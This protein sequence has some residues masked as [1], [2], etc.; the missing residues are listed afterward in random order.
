MGALFGAVLTGAALMGAGALVLSGVAGVLTVITNVATGQPW[1]KNLLANMLLIGL[2][3]KFFKGRLFVEERPSSNLDQPGPV[4]DQPGPVPKP[5]HPG[6]GNIPKAAELSG[7]GQAPD[8]GAFTRAG[9]AFQK[10]GS[11]NPNTWGKPK[12]SPADMNSTGQGILD[13]IINSPDTS[14]QTRHHA[15]F[16][17]VVEGRLPDGRGAR[18]SGDGRNFHGFLEPP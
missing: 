13:N 14:W 18:W 6:V 15:R 10:H 1:D 4:P 7:A 8:T 5:A 17:D 3:S 2:L 11:R 12:G 16:G 9:R